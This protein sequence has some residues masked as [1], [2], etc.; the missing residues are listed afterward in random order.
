MELDEWR[1]PLDPF[2]FRPPVFVAVQL[3]LL[4]AAIMASQA[5]PVSGGST[6]ASALH[7]SLSMP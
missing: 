3:A 5:V 7:A 1:V 2:E 4:V 6:A